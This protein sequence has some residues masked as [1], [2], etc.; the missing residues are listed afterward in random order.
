M[1]TKLKLYQK[2]KKS[3]FTL[4]ETIIAIGITCLTCMMIFSTLQIVWKINA[5][6]T[7]NDRLQWEQFRS[8]IES[9]NLDFKYVRVDNEND[10]LILY[11][12]AMDDFYELDLYKQQI[13]M[14]R[15]I[16]EY[17]PLLYNVQKVEWRYDENRKSIFISIRIHGREYSEEY[18]MDRKK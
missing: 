10:E 9:S 8:V 17:M 11:S 14:R 3:G 5:N 12:D 4:L 15:K 18:I 7:K 16:D 6:K 13:R 1:K 2:S